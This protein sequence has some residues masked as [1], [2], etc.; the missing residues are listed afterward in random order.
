MGIFFVTIIAV[1][2]IMFW[3]PGYF[4][5]AEGFDGAGCSM[6]VCGLIGFPGM[7]LGCVVVAIRMFREEQRR[8]AEKE[9][10]AIAHAAF[11]KQEEERKKAEAKAKQDERTRQ[12]KVIAHYLH[13]SSVD[14]IVKEITKKGLPYKIVIN[15]TSV[16]AY[17]YQSTVEYV[18]LSHGIR[19]FV[20]PD[21]Y[22][23]VHKSGS[24]DM[25]LLGEAINKKL[26]GVFSVNEVV[27]V[28]HRNR[29]IEDAVF[30]DFGRDLQ[31]VELTRPLKSL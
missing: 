23:Y 20:K 24:C 16:V 26:N 3:I 15:F 30:T 9:R 19:N 10:A 31:C 21:P 12:Q 28:V 17:H 22:D 1:I 13:S 4:L 2:W 7:I 5:V 25:Y 6:V 29:H 27:N 14:A 8:K 11:E 18:L